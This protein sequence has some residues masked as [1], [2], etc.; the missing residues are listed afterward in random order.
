M[1]LNFGRRLDIAAFCREV[2]KR[3][4]AAA[5]FTVARLPYSD[6]LE[7]LSETTSASSGSR[8]KGSLSRPSGAR[9][10]ELSQRCAGLIRILHS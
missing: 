10:L 1:A 5:C 2:W 7:S 4:P 9:N 3:E 6:V 8:G